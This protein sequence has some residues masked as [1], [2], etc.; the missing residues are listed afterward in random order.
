M[1]VYPFAARTPDKPFVVNVTHE[2]GMWIA[3][4]DELGLVTEAE[5][6]EALTVRA[7]E[8]AP[9]LV[10]LNGL[11]VEPGDLRLLFQHC[12]SFPVQAAR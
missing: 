9:E 1:N 5:S 11:P 7:W 4:C 3:E 8:A 10:E 2:E 12:E 6:Y